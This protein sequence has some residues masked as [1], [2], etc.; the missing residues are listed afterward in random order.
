MISNSVA[1]LLLPPPFSLTWAL[2]LLSRQLQLSKQQPKLSQ[3][4]KLG[5]F[6]NNSSKK[7]PEIDNE[8]DRMNAGNCKAS[9]D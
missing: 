9:F 4:E 5:A 8:L 2:P 7:E 1:L 6:L 3:A